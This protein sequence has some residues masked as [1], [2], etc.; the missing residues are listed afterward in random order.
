MAAHRPAGVA[1]PS[2]MPTP[3]RR[4]PGPRD[5]DDVQRWR[6]AIGHDVPRRG[7]AS[8]SP[9]GRVAFAAGRSTDVDQPADAL[10]RGLSWC[11]LNLGGESKFVYLLFKVQTARP[12][13]AP[14][15]FA[16][17]HRFLKNLC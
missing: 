4:A 17:G 2:G 10:C 15:M 11:L 6:A 3:R 9:D 1:S 8:T 16:V 5:L 7:S 14:N 12:V 13:L